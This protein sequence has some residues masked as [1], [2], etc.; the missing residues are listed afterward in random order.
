[1]KKI[2]L[3]LLFLTLTTALFAKTLA[4]INGKIN[5]DTSEVDGV[6]G[7]ILIKQGIMPSSINMNDPQVINLKKSILENLI[8]RELLYLTAQNNSPKNLDSIAEEDFKKIKGNFKSEQEYNKYLAENGL[9]EQQ[10]KENIKKNIILQNYVKKTSEKVKVTDKESRE[11][12]EK[13]K[14]SF[15]QQEEVRASHIIIL[16]NKDRDEK[17]AETEINKIYNEIK[18]GLNFEEA[19]KKYSEDGSS[20]VGG[21]LGFFPRGKMV[22]EFEEVAFKMNKGEISKPF[23]SRFGYHILKVTDKKSEKQ[24]SFEE[25]K[26]NIENI[27][28]SEKTKAL[29]DEVI[30]KNRMSAKIEY[31][32]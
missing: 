28:I 24:L 16:F 9:N 11:F 1:M 32:N 18:K 10:I 14:D 6:F 27:L 23:K 25:V 30:E 21:D 13:N 5:I 3:T 17:K 7:S 2:F 22:P 26:Q 8:K 15:K 31:K 29:L 19:A 12:Y 20:Q 4:T